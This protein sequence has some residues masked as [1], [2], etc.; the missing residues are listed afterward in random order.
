MRRQDDHYVDLPAKETEL[1]DMKKSTPV[2]RIAEPHE[3]PSIPTQ[4]EAEYL[5][6]PPPEGFEGVGTVN[7]PVIDL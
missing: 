1:P 5:P 7:V 4:A 3:S 6:E 2:W